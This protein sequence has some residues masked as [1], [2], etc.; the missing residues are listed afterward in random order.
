MYKSGGQR[1][2]FLKILTETEEQIWKQM[3]LFGPDRLY[4]KSILSLFKCK[5]TKNMEAE[6]LGIWTSELIL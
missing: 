1:I 4:I 2:T 6:P 3:T 5:S